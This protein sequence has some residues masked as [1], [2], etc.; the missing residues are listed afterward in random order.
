MNARPDKTED[1]TARACAEW[2]ALIRRAAFR[3]ERRCDRGPVTLC[4]I[5]AEAMR[6]AVEEGAR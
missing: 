5:E 4:E 2:A 6:L 3:L 1:G